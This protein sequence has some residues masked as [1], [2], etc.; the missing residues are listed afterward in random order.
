MRPFFVEIANS[1]NVDK[2]SKVGD[3]NDQQGTHHRADNMADPKGRS[4]WIAR[5]ILRALQ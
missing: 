1:L 4:M 2:C 3:H 5:M